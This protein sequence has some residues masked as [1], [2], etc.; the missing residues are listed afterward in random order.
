MNSL[1]SIGYLCMFQ[2]FILFFCFVSP[3]L[4]GGKS[5]LWKTL[6]LQ[7]QG[8]I[9]PF[10]TFSRELLREVYGRESYKKKSA[11]DVVLS[12]ILI[13]DHWENTPFILLE[14]G[15][16]KKVLGLQPKN[17]RFSPVDF[18]FNQ[19]FASE[20][21]ELQILRQ[22]EES[23]D[24]YFKELQKLE[25]RIV[26]YES[27]KTGWLLKIQPPKEAGA[28]WISLKD[29]KGESAGRFKNA[30]L[31]YASLIT[32]EM[33]AVKDQKEQRKGLDTSEKER[34][35][36]DS[37]S[38]FYREAFKGEPHKWFSDRKIKAEVFYN[39]LHPFR[40][41]WILYFVFLCFY[42][43]LF[44][45]ED[46][47]YVKWTFPVLTLAFFS[48]T[49][50]MILRSYIMSRPP[51]SNMY[52]TVLWVPWVGLIAGMVFYFKNKIAPFLASVIT[53]FFCL[54][55]T[56]TASGVLDGGL[57]PLEAVLR[58]NFWLSAHVLIITMSYSFFFVAFVLGDMALLFFIVRG[59]K[60]EGFIQ[61][62]S[63]SLYRLIQWGVAGLA[64]G[65]ILGA[66][67][68]DYSWGRFWN[69]DPKESWAL[70][71]LLAYITLLHGRLAGWIKAFGFVVSSIG[72][73][74]FGGDGLVWGEFYFRKRASFL[75]IRNRR[76][77]VCGGIFSFAF[78]F[79]GNG[80]PKKACLKVSPMEL[81][82]KREFAS[83][84]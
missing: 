48:H 84:G 57:Q 72:M 42:S 77:G 29:M 12:W 39:S 62:S 63:L 20:I 15:E 52:E 40:I 14:N 55:L 67:W 3:A 30:L 68:A 8:R 21:K 38:L 53:A 78:D 28:E 74:F 54:F 4:A 47:K 80:F 64:L 16:L 34:E 36:E 60:A 82:Q 66:I 51:V 65:T 43:F 22:R 56:D 58:S 41:A 59:K 6:P 25:R 71:T 26:L 46:K 11:V 49:A 37:L 2:L 83:L 23:L 75:W 1:I 69:W 61:D 18:K 35:L 17:R 44:F 32:G 5:D 50:G 24:S 45:L 81:P 76:C 7:H 27:L 73:F 33:D 9:K 70:I 31:S 79:G 13:P 10:D 19:K